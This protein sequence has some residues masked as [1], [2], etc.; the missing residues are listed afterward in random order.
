MKSEREKKKKKTL[1][2]DWQTHCGKKFAL[3][4]SFLYHFVALSFNAF[5]VFLVTNQWFA[6]LA[7]VVPKRFLIVVFI[8]QTCMFCLLFF[9]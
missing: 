6:F 4:C 7:F 3:E 8:S 2:F 5:P 1:F 9:I